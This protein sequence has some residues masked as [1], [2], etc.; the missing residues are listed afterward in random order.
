MATL[1]LKWLPMGATLVPQGQEYRL[2]RPAMFGNGLFYRDGTGVA[3]GAAYQLVHRRF[4][5]FFR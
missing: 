2:Q 5:E 1:C 4:L 3:H